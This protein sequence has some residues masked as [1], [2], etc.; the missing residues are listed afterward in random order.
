MPILVWWVHERREIQG[1][2][3]THHQGNRA[4]REYARR[5]VSTWAETRIAQAS[6]IEARNLTC[7][8]EESF[9]R[10][11]KMSET[12]D[13]DTKKLIDEQGGWIGVD[14]DGTLVEYHG[15][16]DEYTFG[17]PIPEMVERVKKW[18]AEGKTVKIFT[19]RACIP[20]HI[21][22]IKDML[23][24]IGLPRLEVTHKKDY[25]MMELWDDR[26]VQVVPNKGTPIAEA[27][28]VFI[29]NDMVYRFRQVFRR[30]SDHDYPKSTA[31]EIL[32]HVLNGEEKD[33]QE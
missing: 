19:A 5:A 28:E 9:E 27:K 10:Q 17:K 26:C 8:H 32:E 14:L 33:P 4:C 2:I 11:K 24:R 20:S 7:F 1:G 29:T 21:P 16:E 30:V 23:E 31:M 25:K 18:L 3:R 6:S 15:Y 12:L 13:E 22:P